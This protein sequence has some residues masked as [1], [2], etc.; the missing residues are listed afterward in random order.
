MKWIPSVQPKFYR[1]F[2]KILFAQENIKY[3]IKP[4]SS[5]S[6][7]QDQISKIKADMDVN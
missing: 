5:I 7:L 2:N 4:V 6:D 1:Y 3:K